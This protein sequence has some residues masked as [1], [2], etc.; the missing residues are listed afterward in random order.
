M[1]IKVVAFKSPM[2]TE[3]VLHQA[4]KKF[5]EDREEKEI[6]RKRMEIKSKNVESPFTEIHYFD[7]CGC[8][9][10]GN[11]RSKID[12]KR[13]LKEKIQAA[14]FVGVERKLLLRS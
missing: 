2:G 11:L 5:K 10:C 8:K 3:S 6:K 1:A 12:K 7:D 13:K 14:K 9:M 4:P